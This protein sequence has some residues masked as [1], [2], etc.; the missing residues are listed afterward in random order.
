MTQEKILELINQ[1]NFKKVQRN[2]I[3]IVKKAINTIASE[4]I[5]ETGERPRSSKA[6]DVIRFINEYL[7]SVEDQ[8]RM[9]R[10]EEQLISLMVEKGIKRTF[11]QKGNLF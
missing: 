6:P 4:I 9:D 7:G 8:D 2:K 11:S 3:H 5:K 10:I 1:I